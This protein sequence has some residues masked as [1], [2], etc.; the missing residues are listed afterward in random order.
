MSES[1]VYWSQPNQ[2]VVRDG[3]PV[4]AGGNDPPVRDADGFDPGAHTIAEV[5]AYLEANPD[6]R[7]RVLEAERSG[8]ARHRLI[9]D[10]VED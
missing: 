3:E 5:E 8:K 2:Q 1:P 4:A 10:D 9:K 7:D 6:E